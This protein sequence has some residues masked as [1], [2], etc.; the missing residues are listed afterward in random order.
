MGKI[1]AP[2]ARLARLSFF[3]RSGGVRPFGGDATAA[4]KGAGPDGGSNRARATG[5]TRTDLRTFLRPVPNHP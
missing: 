5:A 4:L 2:P 1:P 3:I